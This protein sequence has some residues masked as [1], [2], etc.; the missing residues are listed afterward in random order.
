MRIFMSE[1]YNSKFLSLSYSYAHFHMFEV[2]R[3]GLNNIKCYIVYG[4]V[5]FIIHIAGYYLLNPIE[6]KKTAELQ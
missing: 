1:N 5:L 3:D 2:F 6:E 4:G